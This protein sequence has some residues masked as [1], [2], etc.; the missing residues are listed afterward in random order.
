MEVILINKNLNPVSLRLKIENLSN[1]EDFIIVWEDPISKNIRF[2]DKISIKE[3]G[4]YYFKLNK[5]ISFFDNGVLFKLVYLKNYECFYK[6]EFKNLSFI[7]GKN[8]LYISQ[9]NYSGYSYAARNY[10]YQL[11][12]SNYNVKW[13]DDA[14]AREYVPSNNEEQRVFNCLT[15]TMGDFDSIIIHHTP[16]LWKSICNKIPRGKKIYGL[17]TW[18]TTCLHNS[19]TNFINDSID[20]VIVPSNF[21]KEVFKSSGVNKKINVW[22]HDIFPFD[23]SNVDINVLCDKFEILNDN[24]FLKNGEMVHSILKHNTVYYNIS[25]FVNRK[26]ITQTINAFCNKFNNDDNVCLFIKTYITK[27]SNEE[28]N[29]LKHKI[30]ET[31]KHHDN[32]PHIIFCFV[33]LNNNE[34]DYIHY[35]GDVYYTLNRGEGFGLSSYT[36]KK[37]GNKVIC[38][39]FGAENEFLDDNDIL[40]DY[41]LGSANNLDDFNKFYSDNNQQCAF[42]DSDYVISKLRYFPKVIK[43]SISS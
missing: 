1:T 42:Y 4:E 28:T 20:E 6:Y 27:F 41:T 33:K 40:L 13:N 12:E 32:L 14:M 15:N 39:K 43:K 30:L 24:T 18:E 31:V 35:I 26:N 21:N 2:V 7:N 34:L 23:I 36:A 29:A 11:L 25:Q 16:D 5:D 9:N 10:I 38:G 3:N 37:M 22:R 19:W 17:T 8:I